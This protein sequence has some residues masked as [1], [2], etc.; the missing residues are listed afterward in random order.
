MERMSA[1]AIEPI[2]LSDSIELQKY[3]L[4]DIPAKEL[5]YHAFCFSM[6]QEEVMQWNSSIFLRRDCVGSKNLLA[7]FHV[8]GTS[9]NAL[10]ACT[11]HDMASL[12][13]IELWKILMNNV[14]CLGFV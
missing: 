7:D 2:P 4:S 13:V 12:Y 10:S 11:V 5:K 9:W 14:Q 8:S 3:N 6:Y 1:V